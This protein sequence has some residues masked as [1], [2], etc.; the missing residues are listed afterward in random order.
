MDIALVMDL[1]H[2]GKHA[3]DIHMVGQPVCLHTVHGHALLK[4]ALLH[5]A[6]SPVFLLTHAW[7]PVHQRAH[8]PAKPVWVKDIHVMLHRARAPVPLVIS[9]PA[10]IRAGIPVKVRH[11]GKPVGLHALRRARS[12]VYHELR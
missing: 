11:A 9:L 4:H 8:P 7:V 1:T 5:I 2:A 12:P 3:M 6:L 10:R